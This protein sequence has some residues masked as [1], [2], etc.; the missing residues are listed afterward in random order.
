MFTMTINLR[1]LFLMQNQSKQKI[2]KRENSRLKKFEKILENSKNINEIPIFGSQTFPK[3][4][5]NSKIFTLKFALRVKIE[6][7]FSEI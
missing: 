3:F 2:W 5:E 1:E 7:K 6:Q 4:L